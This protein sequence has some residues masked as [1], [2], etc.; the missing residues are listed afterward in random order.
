[1][2]KLEDIQRGV[3]IDGIFPNR[4]VR[5]ID[6][7][8]HGQDVL[9]ITYKDETGALGSELILRDRENELKIAG[10]RQNW[11]PD[12][13]G[14]LLRLVSE[15]YRIRLA[16]LFDPFLAVHT[17][18][19]EPLPHQITAVYGE[20]LPRQPLKFLLAD[21]P[22]SG[23]T[24]MAG[25]LIKELMMRGDVTRCLII[26]PGNLT[27][28]W[29]EELYSKFSLNFELITRDRV[30]ASLTGNPFEDIDWGIGRLDHLCR[31]PELLAKLEKTDW[32]LIVCDEAHKMSATYFGGE[33]KFTKRYRLGQLL[34]GIC[35]HFLLMTAT[36]HNGKEQDFQL[37]MGLLDPD[38]FEGRFRGGVYVC[39]A[40]DLMRRM[41]KENLVRFDGT[42]LFPE[43]RAY[44]LNY[45]LSDKEARLY[46][47]VTEY[48]REEFNRADALENDGRKGNV[49]FALTILQRRL[50]SSP[51][52]IYQSLRRRRNRLEKR[53]KEEAGRGRDAP[54]IWDMDNLPDMTPED[55][56]ELDDAPH[57]EVEEAED[58]ILDRATAARTLAELRVE[59]ETLKSLENQALVLLRSGQDRKWEELSALLHD[60]PEM[61]S[62]GGDRAKLVIFTE[63]RDTL[64]YLVRRIGT[65]LGAESVS[66]IHGGMGRDA[67]KKA[68]HAFTQ[69]KSVT[70]LIATDAA[71]EGINLQRAHLMV[72]YDLPWNPN[73]LEQRFGRIHRIGQ[74]EVCHL[75]NLV[76]GETRE[77]YVFERLCEKLAQ[78]SAA[79]RGQVF[80][81]LGQAFEECPLRELLL[82][83]IRYGD[84]E[85]VK[86]RLTQVID[87]NLDRAH[88]KSLIEN[89]ALAHEM[90]DISKIR[91][92]RDEMERAEARRLQPHFIRGFFLAGFEQLGGR[93]SPREQGRFEISHVPVIIRN[94]DRQIGTREPVLRQYQRITFHKEF[95]HVPG[96]PAASFICPGHPLLNA[97]IDLILERDRSL[98]RE[99]GILI[100][101]QDPGESPRA[102]FY[103]EHTIQNANMGDQ[104]TRRAVSRQVR[105]VEIS[106]SGDFREAGYAPYLDYRPAEPD[107]Q[108]LL[109]QVLAD[110]PGSDE[111][112]H[113]ALSYAISHIVP[114]HFER[115]RQLNEARIKKIMAAVKERLTKEIA[116]WDRKAEEYKFREE[117]GA[118]TR[119]TWIQFRQRADDLQDR[120]NARMEELE[121]S[122]RLSPAPPVV[123]GRAMV[124]PAGLLARL[125]GERKDHAGMFARETRRVELAAMNAVMLAETQMGNSPR[126]VS[127][128]KCGWDIES[129]DA[130]T[131]CLRFIEVKGRIQESETVTVTKNEILAA[132]NKPD[133]FILAIAIVPSVAETPSADP[134]KIR[135]G[136]SVFDTA[137]DIELYYIS[138]PFDREPG[139]A[140]VSINFSIKELILKGKKVVNSE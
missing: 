41:V 108:P 71:G 17:S 43:R 117:S 16:H 49:G 73:R 44:T 134:W 107:E 9:E 132:L 35:R 21:D 113:R 101:P 68:E 95:I 37:F 90:M 58:L 42:P 100:D 66:A 118:Q 112:E 15:A 83:A 74:T 26:C 72:N 86:A 65:L 12:T 31:N 39:D 25:L 27:E 45:A 1:M 140:E 52:A 7:K 126:D 60:C 46:R 28:Q 6:V 123:I 10:S 99:G 115:I 54:V 104:G 59:I 81:V 55:I 29:Q 139:F 34:S 106:A 96:K 14:G 124:I 80:D 61:F 87:E 4:R 69:D 32:D 57:A 36:P 98:L 48:V 22:G 5:I 30:R 137:Q 121:Q 102:L 56:E 109:A 105:F 122:L 119:L 53:L 64:N 125:K 103:L 135:E 19:V 110:A 88:L 138:R 23:K 76:A 70:I 97:V 3:E 130:A 78:E 128:E 33:I 84:R 127:G 114:A 13:D 51:E 133:Q 63:H 120:L 20:M 62:S 24:I 93:V 131:D 2:A 11:S 67:R 111:L 116:Y 75:W 82:E 40:S 50:A 136:D 91:E 8:R 129:R 92:I 89:R 18:L 85:D 47:E 79:L 38:R 94:R 77:G